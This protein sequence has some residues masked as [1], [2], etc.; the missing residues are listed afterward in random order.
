MLLVVPFAKNTLRRRFT[1]EPYCCCWKRA[2]GERSG[3]EEH[4]VV[5][6]VVIIMVVVLDEIDLGGDEDAEE[7]AVACMKEV[8]G[9][10]SSRKELRP[11]SHAKE[12]RA[13]FR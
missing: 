8:C 3:F 6:S 12:E 9:L 10:C 13:G 1:F 2:V 5:V 11:K 4:V 7:M